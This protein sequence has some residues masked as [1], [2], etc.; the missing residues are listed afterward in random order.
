MS[1]QPQAGPI[2]SQSL[3]D[4]QVGVLGS[5]LIDESCVGLVLS[6]VSE[7]D[8]VSA[9]YRMIFQAVKALFREGLP[10]TPIAVREK[11]G[12]EPGDKLS[13][14]LAGIMDVT[15]TAANVDGYLQMLR[16]K[17]L[18]LRLQSQGAA[19]QNAGDLDTAFRALDRAMELRVGRPDLHALTFAQGYEQFFD[20][21]G[22]E[23]PVEHLD[24]AILQLNEVLKAELGNIVIIGAYPGD[25]KTA[26]ALQC[27]A[28]F[29]KKHNVGYFSFESKASRL[30]DRHVAREA[31]ISSAAI[32]ANKLTEEDFKTIIALR[33][34]LAGTRVTIIDAVGMTASDIAAYSQA[35]HF[36]V[37]FV[38]Y[39]QQV[40][41]PAGGPM[42]DFER[43]TYV[44]RELQ[45]FAVRTDTTVISLSQLSRPDKVK[46]KYKGDDGEWHVRSITPPPTIGDLRSSGQIEQDADIILLMWRE[47]YDIKDSPRIIQVAKNRNGEA[48]DK[49]RC[50]FD[51]EHQTF[52]RI[53]PRPEPPARKPAEKSRQVSFWGD[54]R[55]FEEAPAPDNPFTQEAK[56]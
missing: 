28:R 9:Q 10:T 8:F 56:L 5:M 27:A 53:E 29:G 24:W 23:T 7:R 14:L 43:V 16:E 51:G 2:L 54:G 1:G 32:N 37:I 50:R 34:K 47:D 11:L 55:W 22:E 49:V 3:M 19:L 6:Q 40:E 25:G 21:H 20:R 48:L 30:Y 33:D 45:K 12:G 38:D 35:K 15:A 52:S 31:L 42:K 13:E 18:L 4:A 26:L 44:S 36:D 41:Q 17:S 46:I 39:I